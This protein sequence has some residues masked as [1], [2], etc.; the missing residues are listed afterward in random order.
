[1][2]TKSLYIVILTVF[3]LLI[4]WILIWFYLANEKEKKVI[5]WLQSSNK[6][7]KY[8]YTKFKTKGFPNR[9]DLMYENFEISTKE[10]YYSIKAKYFQIFNVIYQKNL[11]IISSHPEILL[12]TK[13]RKYLLTS[14]KF[15]TSIKKNSELSQKT[16]ITEIDNLDINFDK[17]QKISI[18]NFLFSSMINNDAKKEELDFFINSEDI[19]FNSFNN[20]IHQLSVKGKL[21]N[22]DLQI[23]QIDNLSLKGNIF[24]LNLNGK[25]QI[26]DDKIIYGK[27]NLDMSGWKKILDYFRTNGMIDKNT[28]KLLN[29]GFNLLEI[30]QKNKKI[31]FEIFLN[32]NFIEI[33]P[34]KINNNYKL[35]DFF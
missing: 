19:K 21:F 23:I 26:E 29:G 14:E 31:R 35:E 27:L 4:I 7:E 32:E 18:N 11:T 34:V 24:D 28:L 16:I 33:G 8:K 9:V 20:E 12:K 13:K 17:T 1:M 15:L 6:I 25:V 10:P 2:K 5:N 30:F 22:D 3:S